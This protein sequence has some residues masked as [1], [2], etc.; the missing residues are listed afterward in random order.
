MGRRG[1]GG[2]VDGGGYGD[3]IETGE[4]A[5]EG[6]RVGG[7]RWEEYEKFGEGKEGRHKEVLDSA[8]PGDPVKR[9]IRRRRD[10]PRALPGVLSVRNR[11]L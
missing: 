5:G 1:V 11:I 8:G 9:H 2:R 4:R 7:K 6:L 3:R 10:P